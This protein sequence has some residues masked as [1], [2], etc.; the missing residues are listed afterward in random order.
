MSYMNSY[1]TLKLK[2]LRKISDKMDL[3][4]RKTIKKMRNDGHLFFLSELI[5]FFKGTK[6]F[7]FGTGGSVSN[8]KNVS[9][10]KNY[11]LMTVTLGPLYMHR[12]YGFMPNMWFLHFGP[13]AQ[14]ILEEEKKT[15]LDFSETFILVPAN[16]SQSSVFFSSPIVKE[17]RKR[18][19]EATFVLYREIRS[20]TTFN[21]VHP[22][23]LCHGI[24]PLRALGGGNVE[25]TFLPIC[26]FLGASTLF[27]SGVDHFHST[28][29]FWDRS[30][31]YQSIDGRK[32]DFPDEKLILK[33]A[34][35]AKAICLQKNIKCY[36]LEA[37][38]TVLKTYP[39]IDFE[40]AL[41]QA[42]PKITPKTIRENYKIF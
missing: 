24:E 15:P 23:Y 7:M 13:I 1:L 25:N 6:L 32:I 10:L 14:I 27:F 18:H 39:Y 17:F 41:V 20:P 33:C 22:S 16:D 9:L 29:H 11:N 5:P 35:M 34:S 28:G 19:P 31:F 2:I 4:E 37:E 40:Q 26:A 3:F 42:S 12:M 30:R 36:R 38:E 8:L 21:N